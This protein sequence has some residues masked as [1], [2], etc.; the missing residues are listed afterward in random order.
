MPHEIG[1]RLRRSV[2]PQRIDGSA[3]PTFSHI[4]VSVVRRSEP[5]S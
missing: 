5:S 3:S 2:L 4:L 1:A